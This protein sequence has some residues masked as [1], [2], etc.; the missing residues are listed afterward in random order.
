MQARSKTFIRTQYTP[1]P[2][3]RLLRARS[4]LPTSAF[5]LSDH[6]RQGPSAEAAENLR[7]GRVGAVKIL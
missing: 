7:R 3:D 1:T 5:A 2:S 6:G 4:V